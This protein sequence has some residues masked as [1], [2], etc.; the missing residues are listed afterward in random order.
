[1]ADKNHIKNKGPESIEI[2]WQ[3]ELITWHSGD[4]LNIETGEID[5]AADR[6][7]NQRVLKG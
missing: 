5:R 7:F 4:I 2:I 6:D 1:M 3:G